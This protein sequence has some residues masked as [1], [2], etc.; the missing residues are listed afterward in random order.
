MS[1]LWKDK[2]RTFFGLPLSLTSYE[3]DEERL[4]IR[5]GFF[6]KV[7]DEVRLY[8]IMDVTMVRTL[9]QRILGLGTIHCCST[10]ASQQEFNIT[11]I[12]NPREVKDLLS[13]MVEDARQRHNIYQ[14][15]NMTAHPMMDSDSAEFHNR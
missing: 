13:E 3:L 15:E 10:D 1:T 9:R 6:T 11:S 8:R 2:K 14:H 7:E 4:Y 12:S 5:T